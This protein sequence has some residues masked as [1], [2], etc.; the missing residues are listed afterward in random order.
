MRPLLARLAA[1][2]E[3]REGPLSHTVLAAV[4]AGLL[5]SAVATEALGIHALFGAFLFGALVPAHGRL[6]VGLRERMESVVLVLLLP[7]FFA[8]TGM[9]TRIGLLASGA[10]WLACAAIVAVATV[11]KLGGTALAAR[12]SG[13]EWR[14]ATALGILMNTRGL[15]ELI[16][17][18]LGLDLGVIT[19]EVFTMMVVMA[20]VTT[21]TTPLAL[22]L[23]ERRVP[24]RS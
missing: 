12:A 10:D 24:S 16:V 11:G 6:A 8:L 13:M 9:R 5:L 2:E 7:A 15:M 21:F 1:R 17:L 23:L 14:S 20:L 3:R 19:P 4:F 18:N 22:D